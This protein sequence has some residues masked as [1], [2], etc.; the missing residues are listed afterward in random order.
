MLNTLDQLAKPRTLRPGIAEE[1]EHD[2]DAFRQKSTNVWRGRV[3]QPR[4]ALHESLNVSDLAGKK[5]VQE[6]VL[7]REDSMVLDR[8]TLLREWTSLLPSSR[9]RKLASLGCSCAP[10]CHSNSG[11]IAQTVFCQISNLQVP[12]TLSI[13]RK[14]Q[15]AGTYGHP[16]VSCHGGFSAVPDAIGTSRIGKSRQSLTRDDTISFW[17]SPSLKSQRAALESTAPSVTRRFSFE[18]TILF[19]SAKCRTYSLVSRNGVTR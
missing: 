11:I 10:R 18:P 9:T 2:G 7:H 4:R 13:L 12:L 14:F 17:V 15:Q 3:L 1:I 5:G 16:G 8:P 19:A 6:I